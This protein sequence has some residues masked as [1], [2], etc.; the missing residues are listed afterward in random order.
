MTDNSLQASHPQTDELNTDILSKVEKHRYKLL[1]GQFI[2]VINFIINVSTFA[3]IIWVM[4]RLKSQDDPDSFMN[5]IDTGIN[6]TH[7]SLYIEQDVILDN[8]NIGN[9]LRTNQIDGRNVIITI[10]AKDP[11]SNANGDIKNIVS[12]SKVEISVNP[13]VISMQAR[14]F[15]SN[16]DSEDSRYEFIMPKRLRQL[17]ISGSLQN[18]RSI[19]PVYDGD[20]LEKKTLSINSREGLELSGNKGVSMHSSDLIELNAAKEILI[21]SQDDSIVLKLDG[22]DLLFPS[23]PIHDDYGVYLSEDESD[24]QIAALQHQHELQSKHQLCIEKNTGLLYESG[25]SFRCT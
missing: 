12:S 19:R 9:R 25:D 15:G 13:E 2:F 21:E 11:K 7:R 5:F 18:I 10:D 23:I 8:L 17:D 1:F 16:V 24:E 4:V 14:S 22:G 20:H 6:K 3:A